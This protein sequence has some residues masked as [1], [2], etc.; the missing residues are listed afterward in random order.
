MSILWRGLIDLAAR[1][2]EVGDAISNGADL[3]DT[4]EA[5]PA[6]H[7]RRHALRQAEELQAADDRQGQAAADRTL[8]QH[9]ATGSTSVGDS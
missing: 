1:Q 8:D 6:T 4:K 5:N 9:L 7:K 2:L 3:L